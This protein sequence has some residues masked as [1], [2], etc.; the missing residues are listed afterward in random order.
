[1]MNNN[2]FLK[3]FKGGKGTGDTSF[4]ANQTVLGTSIAKIIMLSEVDTKQVPQDKDEVATKEE[5]K[6]A[7]Y[8][9]LMYQNIIGN[10]LPC[11]QQYDGVKDI[12]LN[13]YNIALHGIFQDF[14]MNINKNT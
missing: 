9:N 4:D 14:E 3:G 6:N 1:M 5:P 11:I 13:N 2:S 8:S 12:K 10:F 7:F